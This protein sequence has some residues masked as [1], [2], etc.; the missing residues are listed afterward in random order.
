MSFAPSDQRGLLHVPA[1]E[2][3][4]KWVSGDIYTMK[5]TKG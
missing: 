4:T 2:G 1:G 3:L 5:A